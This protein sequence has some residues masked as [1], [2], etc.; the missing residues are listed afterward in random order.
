MK[1]YFDFGCLCYS[2]NHDR[3]SD[4]FDATAR[5]HIFLGYPYNQKGWKLYDMEQWKIIMSRDDVFYENNFPYPTKD[6]LICFFQPKYFEQSE[7]L[8]EN[9]DA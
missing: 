5:K 9:M 8:E 7:Y 2:H 1:F 4:K 3:G 6:T